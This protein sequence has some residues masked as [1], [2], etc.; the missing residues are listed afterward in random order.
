MIFL[1][2]NCFS[3]GCQDLIIFCPIAGMCAKLF[4]LD[5]VVHS[6]AVGD[7]VNTV[8]ILQSLQALIA[9]CFTSH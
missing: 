6:I 8:R 5:L 1:V 7:M 3:L 4:A 2:F 9:K